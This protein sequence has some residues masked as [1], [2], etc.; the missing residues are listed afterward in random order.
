MIIYTENKNS[1]TVFPYIL[2][3][4]DYSYLNKLICNY[5]NTRNPRTPVLSRFLS[6]KI[7]MFN[8]GGKIFQISMKSELNSMI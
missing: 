6:H 5:Q 4:V 7:I 1:R 2:T 8:T 3:T